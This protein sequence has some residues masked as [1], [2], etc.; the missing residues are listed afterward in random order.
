ME[1]SQLSSPDLPTI[2]TAAHR[3]AL[4]L[5]FDTCFS[6]LESGAASVSVTPESRYTLLRLF[7]AFGGA[8]ALLTSRSL[9]ETDQL[10]GLPDLPIAARNGM[11]LRSLRKSAAA[12]IYGCPGLPRAALIE[13][14]MGAAPFSGRQP[15]IL[16]G[17]PADDS[18]FESAR[19]LGGF[20]VRIGQGPLQSPYRLPNGRAA[21]AL[22]GQ[23][24]SDQRTWPTRVSA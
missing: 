19:S 8:V 18:A 24:A 17:A 2:T 20:G 12:P 6:T 4:F 7:H 15:V 10:V 21:R 11:E 1:Q 14:L 23:W 5:D 9:L 3:W 13:A 22:L 16:S